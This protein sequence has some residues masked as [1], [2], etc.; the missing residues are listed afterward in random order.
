MT[1]EEHVHGALSHLAGGRIFPDLAEVDTPTPY[2]TYQVVGGEPLN[3]LTG[4]R[5]DKQRVRIQVNVWATRRIEASETGMLVEDALRSV[6]ALQVEVAT[7][8][9]ATYDEPTD[10]RGVMQDFMLFC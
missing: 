5:P 7:G 3:F 2:I 6:T 9:V 1:P 4:D 10:R 8:R